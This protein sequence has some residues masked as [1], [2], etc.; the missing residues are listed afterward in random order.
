MFK[1]Y[2]DS[3]SFTVFRLG[4]SKLF[5]WRVFVRKGWMIMWGKV[6]NQ[7]FLLCWSELVQSLFSLI[8]SFFA[9]IKFVFCFSEFLKIFICCF[10]C[11]QCLFLVLFYFDLVSKFIPKILWNNEWVQ[12][13]FSMLK[14]STKYGHK[15][16]EFIFFCIFFGVYDHLL[17]LLDTEC[18]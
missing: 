4:G 17:V 13:N 8:C 10:L 9:V 1:L 12:I 14:S 5:W 11:N 3:L 7:R 15:S 6:Q 16:S 2:N 18:I